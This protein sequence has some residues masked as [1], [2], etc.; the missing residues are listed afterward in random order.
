MQTQKTPQ[1]NATGDMLRSIRLALGLTIEDA[2]R[3]T[4]I[5]KSSLSLYE[6]GQRTVGN[7]RLRS[8]VT[9]YSQELIKRTVGSR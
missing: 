3:R 5:S 2:A 4:G 6:N 1:R 9:E 7:G 8:I